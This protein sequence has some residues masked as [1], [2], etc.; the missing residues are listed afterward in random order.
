MAM[1]QWDVGTREAYKAGYHGKYEISVLDNSTVGIKHNGI[2]C[3]ACKQNPITGIRW[4]CF[5]CKDASVNL[6]T[7]CYMADEHEKDHAFLRFDASAEK[8]TP[9]EKRSTTS[10]VQARGI[11]PNAIVTRGPDW[12]YDNQDGGR[13]GTVTEIRSWQGVPSCAARVA[14]DSGK[15]GTYRLGYQGKVDLQCITVSSGGRYYKSHLPRLG[16]SQETTEDATQPGCSS[17]GHAYSWTGDQG[18]ESTRSVSVTG[19]TGTR[20][21][22]LSE[23]AASDS[24]DSV[25]VKASFQKPTTV[26]EERAKEAKARRTP[27]HKVAICG[28]WEAVKLLLDHGEDVNQGDKFCLTPLHLAVWYGQES[29]VK[30]LLEHGADVNAKDR[31]Q[32]T[33]MQKAER[34]NH[35]SIIQILK[36]HG[37]TASYKQPV[38]ASYKQS[39]N[40]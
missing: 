40:S 5:D 29:I 2:I 31:F 11:Y 19:D 3:T 32:K 39:S 33:P 37:A 27:L 15:E 6:C 16:S 38:R 8:G 1:V 13:F 30:L 35:Q 10:K 14:W 21:S 36:K 26:W 28:Q 7:S 18:S 24:S 25:Y 34:N 22:E 12:K 9:V 20:A 23:P 4:K 17:E